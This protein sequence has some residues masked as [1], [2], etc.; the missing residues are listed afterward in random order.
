MRHWEAG[1]GLSR[2]MSRAKR[3]HLIR[4]TRVEWLRGG[5]F[6]TR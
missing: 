4:V 3:N 1:G 6:L 2:S 5:L